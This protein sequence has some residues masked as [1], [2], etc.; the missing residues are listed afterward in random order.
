MEIQ[1]IY[2]KYRQAIIRYLTRQTGSVDEAEDLTQEVFIKINKGLKKFR[3]DSSL[4]T[5]IYK[6]ATNIAIEHLR[7]VS[8]RKINKQTVFSSNMDDEL[9][10][11]VSL[12]KYKEPSPEQQIEDDEMSG[13]IH[14]YINQLNENYRTVILLCDYEGLKNKEAA[15]VLGISL[16]TVKIRLHRAR[17]KMKKMVNNGCNVYNKHNDELGCDKK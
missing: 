17:A 13:C 2:N 5:W 8:F 10:G 16:E 7:S 1:D 9:K 15:E 12:L 14:D 6:I 3:G 4:S 11:K